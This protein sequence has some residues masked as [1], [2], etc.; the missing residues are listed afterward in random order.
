MEPV[1]QIDGQ[2]ILE[3]ARR[4]ICLYHTTDNKPITIEHL[5]PPC[6]TTHQEF[7]PRPKAD[8]KPQNVERQ[9]NSLTYDVSEFKRQHKKSHF[10]NS[11]ITFA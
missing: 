6:R 10:G 5:K 3:S 2:C 11:I 8:E 4:I 1:Y 9:R 7:M